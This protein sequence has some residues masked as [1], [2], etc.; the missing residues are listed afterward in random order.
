MNITKPLNILLGA[1]VLLLILNGCG[2]AAPPAP[3]KSRTDLVLD[4][5]E[6]LDHRN[7]AVALKKVERLREL[8]PTNVFL[9]NLEILERNNV[10]ITEAQEEI[11]RGDLPGALEKVNEGIKKYGRHKDLMTASKKLAVATRINEILEVFKDPKEAA[12]L[13]T[14]AMQLK[15]IASKYRPAKPFLPLAEEKILE[16]KRMDIWETKR[17]IET[18]CSYIDEMID[19]DDPDIELLFAV[20]EVADPY[21]PTLLKYLDYLKG[22]DTLTL[23]TYDEDEIFSTGFVEDN[24]S[25]DTKKVETDQVQPDAKNEKIEPKKTEEKE[26]KG[27]WNKFTF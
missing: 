14:A 26:K 17:G 18:F 1:S 10:I 6:T 23:K 9:A 15:E 13:R 16:A 22:N 24:N 19:K 11:N 7:H 12:N 2:K 4:I 21:N 3:P 20:L 8:D 25:G 5:L 27:W